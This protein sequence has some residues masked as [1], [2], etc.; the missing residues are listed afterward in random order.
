MY[1][2]HFFS[3]FRQERDFLMI[4]GHTQIIQ[5]RS[6]VFSIFGLGMACEIAVSNM[7]LHEGLGRLGQNTGRP[8]RFSAAPKME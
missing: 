8:S 2:F 7:A 4:L 6:K 1:S 5:G 3:S